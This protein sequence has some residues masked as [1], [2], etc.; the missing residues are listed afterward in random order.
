MPNMSAGVIR[1]NRRRTLFAAM[2]L[3]LVTVMLPIAARPAAAQVPN[4]LYGTVTLNGAPAPVGATV[5]AI[6]GSLRCGN[7]TVIPADPN[8]N[9][10][11]MNVGSAVGDRDCKPGVTVTFTVNGQPAAQSFTMDD[12]GSFQRINLTAPGTPPVSASALALAAGCTEVNSTFAD[13]ATGAT[14]AAAITPAADVQ[15]IW[16]YDQAL[17]GYR[18]YHPA[19]SAANDLPPVPRGQTLRICVANA[20]SLAR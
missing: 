6:S 8:G 9:T 10:W 18:G 5:Q 2:A 13:G 19:A 16:W 3:A 12:L 20:A 4:R 17:G 14:I 1:P 15:G 11:I 7:T